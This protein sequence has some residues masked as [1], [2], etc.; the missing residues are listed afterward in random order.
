MTTI[1]PCDTPIDS[2]SPLIGTVKPFS[3]WFLLEEAPLDADWGSHEVDKALERDEILRT[4][5]ASVPGSQIAFIRQRDR[6]RTTRRLYVC[7]PVRETLHAADVT[8]WD[9]LAQVNATGK[10]P[11][12][13]GAEMQSVDEPLY[14]VCTNT[15]RDCRC[16]EFGIPVYDA[17]REQVGDSAWESTHITGHKFAATLYIFPQA[18]AYGRLSTAHVPELLAAQ[19][20][21]SLLLAHYRGRSPYDRP[22]Q[23]AE[24]HLL[25]QSGRSGAHDVQIIRSQKHGNQTTIWAKV[26]GEET[27]HRL[28]VNIAEDGFSVLDPAQE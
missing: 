28:V 27:L 13:A 9:D 15:Q 23:I 26:A 18:I 22:E 2:A 10:I 17:L 6:D 12:L 5:K 25:R 11:T 20:K 14:V 4:L 8:T 3:Y 7:D 24:Q 1:P 21:D 19:Q 16:G